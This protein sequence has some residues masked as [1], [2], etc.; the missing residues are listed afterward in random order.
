MGEPRLSIQ[1]GHI[2]PAIIK[3]GVVRR[4][5]DDLEEEEKDEK[6]E[7]DEADDGIVV[8][9]ILGPDGEPVKTLEEDDVYKHPP[10]T[11][12]Q[13]TPTKRKHSAG[14]GDDHGEHK[15]FSFLRGLSFRRN[16]NETDE[17]RKSKSP[18]DEDAKERKEREKKEK[19]EKRKSKALEKEQEKERKEKE[20]KEKAELAKQKKEKEKE[21][22]EKEK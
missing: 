11:P 22:K 13:L 3:D 15:R 6:N 9:E 12:T 4:L 1:N 18:S 19:E 17:K 8:I 16:K 10:R 20:K 5:E 2:D 21:R 7:E 14:S